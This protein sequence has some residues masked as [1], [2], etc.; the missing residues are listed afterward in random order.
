MKKWYIGSFVAIVLLMTGVINF[1]GPVHNKE[2]IKTSSL[3]PS[4]SSI[5][6]MIDKSSLVLVGTIVGVEKPQNININADDDRNNNPFYRVYTV[7]N[8][9]VD[10]VIKGDATV[11]DI[12]HIKQPGGETGEQIV[13]ANHI[14]YLKVADKGLFFLEAFPNGVP[15][16]MLNPYQASVVERDGII[17]NSKTN[18]LFPTET[19]LNDAIRVTVKDL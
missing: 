18:N 5:N 1:Y 9:K 4:F 8:L 13:E 19:S 17:I 14:K 6:E 11:G 7:S 3:Y 16:E 10:K 12:I 15:C 2:V